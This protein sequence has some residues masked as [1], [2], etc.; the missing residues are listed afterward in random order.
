MDADRWRRVKELFD[1]I[2]DCPPAD[3]EAVKMQRPRDCHHRS[4]LLS[5]TGVLV[6]FIHS[7]YQAQP[8]EILPSSFQGEQKEKAKAPPRSKCLERDRQKSSIRLSSEDLMKLVIEKRALVKPGLLGRNQLRGIV[9]VEVALDEKGTVRCVV[10]RSG[11][12][13]AR[14]SAVHSISKWVFKPYVVD[15]NAKSV[16]GIII[17]PYDFRR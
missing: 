15:D 2:L 1:K 17:I 11:H 16:F 13:L 5:F 6:L 8:V 14:D 12:P 7:S 4:R 9:K 10:V 3:Q